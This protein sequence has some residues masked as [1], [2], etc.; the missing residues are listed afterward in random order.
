MSRHRAVRNL[1]LEEELYD[2]EDDGAIYDELQDVSE[3]DQ[4][5]LI[6]GVEA[7]K[8]AIGSDTGIEDREI[9]ES[10]WYYF[11]DEEATIAWLQ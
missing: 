9:K 8:F 2:E 10:L 11:F 6:K 1:N 3:D 7:V 4:A 5:R